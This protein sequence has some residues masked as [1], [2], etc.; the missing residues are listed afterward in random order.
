MKTDLTKRWSLALCFSLLASLLCTTPT[1]AQVPAEVYLT[2]SVTEATVGDEFDV[3]VEISASDMFGYEWILVFDPTRLQVVD[4]DS[5]QEGTQVL[6]GSFL[7]PDQG[8]AVANQVDNGS[9]RV[10]CALTLLAPA[11]SVDGSGQLATVTFRAVSSGETTI[12][13]KHVLLAT[14][15][16]NAIPVS[17]G[18]PLTVRVSGEAPVTMPGTPVPPTPASLDPTSSASATP[19]VPPRNTHSTSDLRTLAACSGAGG[20]CLLGFGVTAW[21]RRRR[22]Q[23]DL[24]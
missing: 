13:L 8:Y 21:I 18:S 15:D 9:G 24:S 23:K 20:L 1:G 7:D 11:S 10:L 4:A 14:R 16:G 12:A 3:V 17:T 22:E 5:T 19:P 6:L 2:T